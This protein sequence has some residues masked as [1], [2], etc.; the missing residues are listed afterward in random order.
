M[1]ATVNFRADI[2]GVIDT[3]WTLSSTDSSYVRCIVI[4]ESVNDG[5]TLLAGTKQNIY[6]LH[7]NGSI[8][9][10]FEPTETG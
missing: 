6:R 8:D 9:A 5:S 7:S 3:V 2:A 1:K 10:L 4:D